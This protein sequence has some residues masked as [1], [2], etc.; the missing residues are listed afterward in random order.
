MRALVLSGGAQKGSYEAGAIKYLLGELELQYSSL[1]GVSVG[2]IN[3][4]FIAQFPIGQEKQCAD[5]LYYLWSQIKSSSIYKRWFPFGSF[6]A[7]WRPGFYDSSPLFKL[8]HSVISL[9]RIRKAGKNVSIGVVCLNSGKYHLI[10]QN[11]DNFLD[12]VVASASF[13]VVFAPIKI[14][15]QLWADGGVKTLSPIS[16][17]ID[18]GATTI[19]LIMTSP[20]KRISK[21]IEHPGTLDIL[22]RSIDLSTDKIMSNDIEKAVM[23][24][25]LASAGILDKRFVNINVIRPAY[26]LIEDLLDFDPIKIQ[27]MMSKGYEDAKKVI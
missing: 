22:K 3:C 6:H 14:D 18:S 24:N 8:V 26:N 15:G 20:D 5:E 1:N 17:A 27:E 16:S 4:A 9:D 25:K 7:L 11:N 23:Y 2:A 19:D 13:P 10:D 12:Y 21:W